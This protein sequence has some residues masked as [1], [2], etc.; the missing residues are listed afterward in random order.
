[1]T[2]GRDPK[3]AAPADRW[4]TDLS[5]EPG[6]R[7]PYR[8]SSTLGG[9]ITDFAYDWR[10]HKVPPLQVQQADPLQ[11]M[12]LEAADQ[13][14]ID[15]GYDKKP[16]DRERL[17]VLVGTEF[18]GDFS[19]HL[20]L[21]LRLPHLEKLLKQMFATHGIAAERSASMASEFGEAMLKH[22]PALVDESGSFSTSTLASRIT[23]SMNLMGGAAAID[24][25]DTSAAAAIGSSVDMLLSGD[26]DMMLCASGQRSMNLPQYEAMSIMG[27]LATGDNPAS[28]FDASAT[29][30]VPGE[31]VGVLLLK[32]LSDARRDGDPIRGIIRGVGAGHSESLEESLRLA[33]QRALADAGVEPSDVALVEMDGT[34]MPDSDQE[35]I[36]AVLSVY[37]QQQRENP[38]LVSSITGQIGH[39]VGASAMPAMIKAAMEID[40]GE[41]PATFG[42][43]NPLPIFEQ[44]AKMIHAAT[45]ST[46]IRQMTRDGRRF[47]AVSSWGKG[48]AYHVLIERG[49]K[50]PVEATAS[51]PAATA[52]PLAA[53]AAAIAAPA[54][55]VAAAAL[56]DIRIHRFGAATP[57]ELAARLAEAAANP[58]AAFAAGRTSRFTPADRSRV[59]IVAASTDALAKKLQMAARQ[60]AAPEAQVVLEQQG[61]FYRQVPAGR[62]RVAFLFPGQGSQYAGMFQQLVQDVPAAASM[63]H[64]ID[65][66]MTG[67]AIRRLRR[68][69]GT[70]RR[71]WARTFG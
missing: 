20:E 24:S 41:M 32:R 66:V 14:L 31:G 67:A 18:G 44:N 36:R 17:A 53:Q 16:F 21:G 47:A 11:F 49:Q 37:G 48:L 3:Q 28:P 13:A 59:A 5:Y 55:T 34:G 70:T 45:S 64:E 4:R 9:Y 50:V 1:M 27:M 43:K 60:F 62:P 63:M 22:W 2:S 33:M 39:T 52:R 65:A 46:P 69:L 42:L 35:E 6:S 12:L 38:L 61:C 25:S 8:T 19:T 54:P 58:Q 57:A 51:R 23:K 10:K 40:G 26:C 71:S 29:G 30:L 56:H 7:R 68:W 15:S